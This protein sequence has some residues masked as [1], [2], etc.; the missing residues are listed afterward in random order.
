MEIPLQEGVDMKNWESLIGARIES[1]RDTY[2]PQRIKDPLT[3][4]KVEYN[5]KWRE[6]NPDKVKIYQ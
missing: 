4:R 6:A 5:K 3:R 2:K 1:H